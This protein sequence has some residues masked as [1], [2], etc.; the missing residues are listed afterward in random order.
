MNMAERRANNEGTLYQRKDDLWCA[1][2]SRGGRRLSKYG[3]TQRE[4][5]DWIRETLAKINTGLT[6]ESIHIT[7]ESFINN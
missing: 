7:L 2:V 6:H 3:K 1:Q 4:C 5:Y